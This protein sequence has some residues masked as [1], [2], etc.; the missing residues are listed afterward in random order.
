MMRASL[1]NEVASFESSVTALPVYLVGLDY[2]A[3]CQSLSGLVVKRGTRIPSQ[4]MA[5]IA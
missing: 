3:H 5:M 2:S 1:S 4:P